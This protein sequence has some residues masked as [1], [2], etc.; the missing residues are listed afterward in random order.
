MKTLIY[1]YTLALL[2]IFS[3][4][5]AKSDDFSIEEKDLKPASKAIDS[6]IR[7]TNEV[8]ADCKFIGKPIDLSGQGA[9]SDFVVTTANACNWGASAGPVWIIRGAKIVLSTSAY[10]IKL[11]SK[12]DNGLFAIQTSHGSAGVASVEYWSFTG[13]KYKK[14]QSYIFTPDDEKTCKDHKDICPWQF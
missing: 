7:K 12:K 8:E 4:V 10:A 5:V 1:I 13:K 9:K 6:A 3:P 11:K 2:L 14:T